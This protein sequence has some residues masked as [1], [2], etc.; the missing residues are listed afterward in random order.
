MGDLVALLDYEDV[1]QVDGLCRGLVLP[2]FLEGEEVVLG[3]DA[4]ATEVERA[5]LRQVLRMRDYFSRKPSCRMLPTSSLNSFSLI[6]IIIY[7]H[8]WTIQ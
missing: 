4:P 6:D 8:A 7:H 5:Y 3:D 1:G 2:L